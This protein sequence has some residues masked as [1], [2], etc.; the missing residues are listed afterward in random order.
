M[1]PL[2]SIIVPAYNSSLFIKKC[3]ESVLNQ[4]CNDYELILVDD[5]SQDETLLVCDSYAKDSSIIKVVH[6]ENGGHTSARNEGIYQSSGRFIIFLDSDDWLSERT[7]EKCRQNILDYDSDIVVFQMKNSTSIK[8]FRVLIEDGNYVI[9]KYRSL[10]LGKILMGIDGDYIFPKSLSG[11]C[12][13]REIIIQSQL[14]VP[15]DI[16]IGEDGAAFVGAALK[17]KQISVISNDCEACYHC[18]VRSG[19][20]S[21]S[22]DIYAFEKMKSL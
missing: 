1:G 18:L 4:T 9:N 3:I 12:F 16:L 14:S 2:F 20:V 11:K 7:L 19:S 22:P 15:K 17:A 5:G 6:K 21:R 8:P 10:L 13:R